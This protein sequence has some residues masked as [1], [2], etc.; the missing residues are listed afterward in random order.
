MAMVIASSFGVTAFASNPVETK[1]NWETMVYMDNEDII[2]RVTLDDDNEVA[3]KLREFA[4]FLEYSVE[5]NGADKSIV[6]SND[7]I[8]IKV[9]VGVKEC[10]ING[11]KVAIEKPIFIDWGS[12][13]LPQSFLKA[14]LSI[15]TVMIEQDAI[16]RRVNGV[17]LTGSQID[18]TVVTDT[19]FYLEV[20]KGEKEAL[21]FE[22]ALGVAKE[23]EAISAD[24]ELIVVSNKYK[25]ADI[26]LEQ[27][28]T[29]EKSDLSDKEKV[30]HF[31]M[32]C[33][34]EINESL[35]MD[36]VKSMY[37]TQVGTR[38]AP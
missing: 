26:V 14:V 34:K 11:E 12:A 19:A 9:I 28:R 10:E 27:V 7:T 21:L 29:L 33:I 25:I 2:T 20:Q 16:G 30:K 17:Y 18:V 8:N 13:Y 31:K 35:S 24:Y 36:I 37:I 15:D 3:I 6:L 1:G 5:W 23:S 4:G 22:F 32:Q 38:I